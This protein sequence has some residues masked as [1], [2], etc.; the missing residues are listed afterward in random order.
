MASSESEKLPVVIISYD[1]LLKRSEELKKDSGRV[2]QRSDRERHY[3]RG[4][5]KVFDGYRRGGR[6]NEAYERS[7]SAG[8]GTRSSARKAVGAGIFQLEPTGLQVPRSGS[9]PVRQG[10]GHG[11]E[12]ESHE[13]S[14]RGRRGGQGRHGSHNVSLGSPESENS[15]QRE[16]LVRRREKGLVE[17]FKEREEE[18]GTSLKQWSGDEAGFKYV[19]TLG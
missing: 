5:S 13:R 3:S 8:R 9:Q 10:R 16:K 11:T 7:V 12:R 15:F 19:G 4:F 14:R 6:G 2:P 1:Q 18:V 17:Q